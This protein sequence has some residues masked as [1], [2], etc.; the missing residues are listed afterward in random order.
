MKNK[1]YLLSTISII[2]MLFGTLESSGQQTFS[3]SRASEI[4][5]NKPE[6]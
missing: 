6:V 2:F 4:K 5:G 1:N 3:A